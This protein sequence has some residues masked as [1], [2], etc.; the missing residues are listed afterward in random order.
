MNPLYGSR[1]AIGARAGT[2]AARIG[3]VDRDAGDG[4]VSWDQ[5]SHAYGPAVEVPGWISSLRD[6]GTAEQC[7][8]ELYGSIT[9]QGSRYS[10]TP[11]CV[12]LLVDAALDRSV[13]DRAARSA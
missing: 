2:E 6:P 13:V 10:A 1:R 12:P 3:Q 11:L 9:H 4:E 5:V 8:S 7:L